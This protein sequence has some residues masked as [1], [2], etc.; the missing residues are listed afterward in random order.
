MT[1]CALASSSGT[2]RRV[3]VPSGASWTVYEQNLDVEPI[4]LRPGDDVWLSWDPTHAFGVPVDEDG[5]KAAL[6]EDGA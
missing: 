5:R 6:A 3:T 4:S 2:W 1:R